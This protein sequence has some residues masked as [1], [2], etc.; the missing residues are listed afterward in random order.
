MENMESTRLDDFCAAFS[1]MLI[2]ACIL[3]FF[4][5]ACDRANTTY[6]INDVPSIEV[7][8]GESSIQTKTIIKSF[9]Q[10]M[11]CDDAAE[12]VD[13][14]YAKYGNNVLNVTVGSND[15]YHHNII[16][17]TVRTDTAVSKSS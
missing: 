6:T 12:F 16:M 2:V 9:K 13:E 4:C 10:T 11:D 14:C 17:V 15:F 8:S 3:L 5:V 1:S 7:K